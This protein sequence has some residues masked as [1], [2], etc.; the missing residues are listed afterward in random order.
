MSGRKINFFTE[1]IKLPSFLK[2]KV[3][4]KSLLELAEIHKVTIININYIFCNDEYL[5]G[6]NNQYL[7][8][9][10]YTDIITFPYKEGKE[11]EGEIFISIDRIR[12]NAIKQKTSFE[13]E[14]FRV[15]SHGLLHLIG[16]N[17]KSPSQK[18]TM[19][20]EEN[21]AIELFYSNFA[22]Q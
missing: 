2:K 21:K 22:I 10:F 9:D 7:N 16:F 12:D 15:I 3:L 1:D 4:K 14:L 13:S 18:K 8:H 20:N 6:I 11:I 19:R 17:D 5:L